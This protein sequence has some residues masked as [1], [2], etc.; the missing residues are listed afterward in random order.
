MKIKHH[1]PTPTYTLIYTH[2]PIRE[3]FQDRLSETAVRAFD[4]SDKEA[5]FGDPADAVMRGL[6]RWID[7]IT[8]PVHGR[9]AG[10]FSSLCVRA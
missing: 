1:T 4:D 5:I 2:A 6:L 9:C 7:D 8:N 3:E 10:V